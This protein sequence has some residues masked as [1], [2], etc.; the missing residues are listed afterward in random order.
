MKRISIW[1]TVAALVLGFARTGA[2]ED[3]NV[4]TEQEKADGWQLLFDGTTLK[5]WHN[6]RLEGVAPGWQVTN[7]ALVCVDPHHAGDIVTEGQFGWFELQLDY[8]ISPGGN[9]GIMYHVVD[10]GPAMWF[11]GPEFQLE[12]NAK[13]ADPVRCGWLYGL[14]QPPID[15]ATGEDAGCDEAGGGMEPYPAAGQP[16][17]VRA[18][19]QWRQVF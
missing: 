2:A 3:N 14:Y 19:C 4:L 6:F 8:N 18:R 10:V 11:S 17:E 16:A 5:G 15:P 9:S 7:G 1:M 12:D 13:A